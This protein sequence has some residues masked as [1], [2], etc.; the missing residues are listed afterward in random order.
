MRTI[1]PAQERLVVDGK[2]Q[3]GVFDGPFRHAN[4]I[5]VNMGVPL[6]RKLKSLRLKEWQAFQ[7][8]NDDVFVNVALFNAKVLA[9]AQVKVYDRRRKER[10]LV[11]RKLP[12]WS[13]EIPDNMWNSDNLYDGGDFRMC[14]RNRLDRDELHIEF[15]LEAGRDTPAMS[16]LLSAST[17][18]QEPLVVSLPFGEHRGMYSHKGLVPISGQLVLGDETM[19]FRHAD[20]YLL[21]DDHKGY[22]P[23]RMQWEWLCAGGFDANGTLLGVNLTRNQVIEPERYNENCLWLGGKRHLLPAIQIDQSNLQRWHVSD[24]EGRVE[25][26]FDIETDSRLDINALVVR[27]KYRGPFGRLSGTL[28]PEGG[29]EVELESLF[30]MGEEFYLRC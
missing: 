29:P 14:F 27:S 16:G 2:A 23:Y 30:G 8:G 4:L 19:E 28:R 11:E 21:M 22:Y 3:F 25:L 1:R 6:P 26:S 9:L 10:I 18:G 15:E 7:F 24:R 13:L 5:D 12:P 20:S 17:K